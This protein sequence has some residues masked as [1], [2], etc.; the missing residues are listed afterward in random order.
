MVH[1]KAK[2]KVKYVIYLTLFFIYV[3]INYQNKKGGNYIMYRE[4]RELTQME[5]DE[6]KERFLYGDGFLDDEQG[7][8]S[9]D[10][11]S[12][13]EIPNEKIFERYGHI[14]FTE[15]DFFCNTRGE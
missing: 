3:I 8:L 1:N 10:Y 7:E 2:N 14:S 11:S 4:V 9:K 5:L 12:I 15:E 13:D 6:L